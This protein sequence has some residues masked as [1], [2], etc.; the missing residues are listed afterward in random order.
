MSA[1]HQTD[2]SFQLN[3]ARAKGVRLVVIH[4]HTKHRGPLASIF[5]ETFGDQLYYYAAQDGQNKLVDFVGGL[6]EQFA[7]AV[8]GFGAK[9][10]AA[11][12]AKGDDAKALAKALVADMGAGGKYALWLDE[13]DRVRISDGFI[14]FFKAVGKALPDG[15]KLILCTRQLP[16][17]PW[18]EL[19]AEDD[20]V[21][22]NDYEH[23]IESEQDRP[24]LE[25]YALGA[26][27]ALIN[28]EA[29]TSWDGALPR[30]LFFF[31]VDRPL[32]TRDEVFATFWPDLSVKE[33]TNVFHVTKRKISERLDHELTSYNSGFY[34]PSGQMKVHYDAVAFLE[35]IE[36]ASTLS[37]EE[38][39]KRYHHAIDLYRGD[40]LSSLKMEWAAERRQAL[41]GAYAQ[42]LIALG[43]IHKAEEK[44]VEALGYFLRALHETPEREDIH[45]EVMSLYVALG[46]NEDAKA[47]Y[48]RLEEELD[49]ELGISPSRESRELF[50]SIP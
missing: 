12:D 22:L 33:A 25:V 41:K 45:R 5:V 3:K 37:D 38:A 14:A 24:L 30:N 16:H 8:D 44:S 31:F 11:L 20:T 17:H 13:L 42:A 36:Q 47:Q 1:S 2:I 6:V 10:R 39:I 15:G 4:P 43:R 9:T 19:L 21:I 50:E 29:I 48:R 7:Q 46:R 26:G 40:F 32:V 35:S 23:P 28:G 18:Q 34:I 27:N 49:A